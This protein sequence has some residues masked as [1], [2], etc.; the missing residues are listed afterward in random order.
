MEMSGQLHSPVSLPPRRRTAN[1]FTEGS[2]EDYNNLFSMLGI[3]LRLLDRPFC[4]KSRNPQYGSIIEVST[5]DK[6]R[7]AIQKISDHNK[8]QYEP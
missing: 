4:T 1:P 2:Y 7:Y 6:H 8:F 3:E 5:A